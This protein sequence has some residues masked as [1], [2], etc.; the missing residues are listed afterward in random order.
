MSIFSNQKLIQIV[1]YVMPC[2]ILLIVIMEANKFFKDF[3]WAL[4]EHYLDELSFWR[5][6]FIIILGLICLSPMFFYDVILNRLLQVK[7]PMQKLLGYS[8]SANAYSNLIGF[9]GVAGATLRTVYYRPYL[10]NNIPYIKVIAKLSLFYLCGLSILS[11]IVLFNGSEL[12]SELRLAH[13]AIW[14]VA[15]YT[16]LLLFVY[17]IKRKLQSLPIKREFI[18]ELLMISVFEWIFVVICIW[19]ILNIVGVNFSLF[20]VFPIVIVAACAGIISMLPGGI[21]SFDLVI[22]IGFESHG[23]PAE[24][25]FMVLMFYRL[26]YYFIPAV[27]GTPVVLTTI[28]GHLKTKNFFS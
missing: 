1:K 24:L 4:L 8:L 7:I 6:F 22:L 16:P 13:L 17:F 2:I 23:I 25:T 3:N 9:G 5:I 12:F 14:I 26:S 28:C 11:W 15:L 20:S 18:T 21:G 27:V 10:D 19:G